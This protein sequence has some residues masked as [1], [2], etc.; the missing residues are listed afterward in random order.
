MVT[1]Q[2]WNVKKIMAWADPH[3]RKS[4]AFAPSFPAGRRLQGN[5]DSIAESDFTRIFIHNFVIT[6]LKQP[7][8]RV[9]LFL[10]MRKNPRVKSD[11]D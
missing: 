5:A 7:A 2:A 9:R 1:E 10:A 3:V 11:N 8:I 4:A 6:F